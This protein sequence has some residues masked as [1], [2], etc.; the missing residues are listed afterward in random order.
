MT[1]EPSDA[2]A[3]RKRRKLLFGAGFIGCVGATL[4]LAGPFV[5]P[6]FRRHCLPYLPATDR[7]VCEGKMCGL[8]LLSPA[9]GPV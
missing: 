2:E 3:T 7:T 5:T 4:A 9:G 1:A 6:A 8:L